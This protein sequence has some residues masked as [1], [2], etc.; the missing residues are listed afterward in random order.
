MKKILAILL[1][2]LSIV[3]GFEAQDV[4]NDAPPAAEVAEEV[5]KTDPEAAVDSESKK[6]KSEDEE[7][8]EKRPKYDK[9][10][11]KDYDIEVLGWGATDQEIYNDYGVIL[12]YVDDFM[13]EI[14]EN[15]ILSLFYLFDSAKL[16][17]PKDMTTMMHRS[18]LTPVFKE[19]KGLAKFY[20][21]DC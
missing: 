12:N 19:L 14:L 5:S 15:D 1:F 2:G 8:P 13:D 21:F 4:T 11:K 7:A 6:E 9:K 3:S 10:E 16:E 17:N 18:V 20:V